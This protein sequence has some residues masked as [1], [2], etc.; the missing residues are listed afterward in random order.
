MSQTLIKIT[1]ILFISFFL[2][3][4]FSQSTNINRRH[5]RS[6]SMPNHEDAQEK[7]ERM[8]RI[9]K[10]AQKFNEKKSK[11]DNEEESTLESLV[12]KQEQKENEEK[13]SIE[14]RFNSTIQHYSDE[15]AQESHAEKTLEKKVEHAKKKL[16]PQS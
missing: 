6:L 4:S 9:Q 16:H 2:M 5:T 14:K 8:S 12:K 1:N 11:S 15:A 3:T 7:P 10:L 13:Q